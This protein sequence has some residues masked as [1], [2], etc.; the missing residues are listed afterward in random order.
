MCVGHR[1]HLDRLAAVADR[2]AAAARDSRR[3]AEEYGFAPL[4]PADGPV[5]TAIFGGNNAR[6]YNFDPAKRAALA[7]DGIAEAKVAYQKDG[8][9]GRTNLAYGYV[10]K[11]A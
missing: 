11:N 4:G 9:I 6:L 2:G 3:A 1:R 10:L 5:K 7:R 8:S